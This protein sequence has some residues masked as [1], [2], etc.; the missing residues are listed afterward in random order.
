[1]ASVPVDRIMVLKLLPAA[2]VALMTSALLGQSVAAPAP[3]P[4]RAAPAPPGAAAP[5]ASAAASGARSAEQRARPKKKKKK[6]RKGKPAYG[7]AKE[8]NTKAVN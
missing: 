6:K 3:L 1:L 7:S 8:R 5:P 4:Q 2:A